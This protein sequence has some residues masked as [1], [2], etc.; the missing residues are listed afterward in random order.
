M[1]LII[2]L[3]GIGVAEAAAALNAR[4]KAPKSSFAV[5][6]LS[7]VFFVGT[8]AAIAT[9]FPGWRQHAGDIEAFQELSHDKTL[10]AVA[11]YKNA[12]T[13]SGGY[14]YLHRNVPI[15]LFS[16]ESALEK[17]APSFNA[18]VTSEPLPEH[19]DGFKVAQCWDSRH[20]WNVPMTVCL[21]Q[22]PGGCTLGDA[23]YEVNETLKRIDE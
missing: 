4:L 6:A 5:V 18:L 23:E 15:Y 12:W 3:S 1:P 10:C 14:T 19:H 2:T 7:A 11:L 21:Y 9:E 8:S 22:R 16:D 20:L 13:W 17:L